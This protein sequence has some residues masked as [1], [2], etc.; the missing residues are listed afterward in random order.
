MCEKILRFFIPFWF[1]METNIEWGHYPVG[2]DAPHRMQRENKNEIINIDKNETVKSKP[3]LHCVGSRTHKISVAVPQRRFYVKKAAIQTV[4]VQPYVL[5]VH[6]MSHT[7]IQDLNTKKIFRMIH[8]HHS[9]ATFTL[10]E[11]ENLIL[12]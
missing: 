5:Y 4:S 3:S 1:C 12:S 8:H 6:V 9:D 10:Q 7:L 2:E 11:V